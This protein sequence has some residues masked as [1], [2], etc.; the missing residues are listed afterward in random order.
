MEKC[1]YWLVPKLTVPN[2][3]YIVQVYFGDWGGGGGVQL[4]GGGVV[5]HHELDFPISIS[6]YDSPLQL[7]P[8]VNLIQAAPPN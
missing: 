2:L 1:S 6:S 8:E 4:M 5:S 3:P 7:C